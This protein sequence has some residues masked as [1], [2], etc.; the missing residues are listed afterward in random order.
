MRKAVLRN[1]CSLL[2]ETMSRGR[3]VSKKGPDPTF[4]MERPLRAAVGRMAWVGNVGREAK[5]PRESATIHARAGSGLNQKLNGCIFVIIGG[6]TQRFE[7]S[8]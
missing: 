4:L 1:R 8:A 3:V 2:R 7:C 6:K 5:K